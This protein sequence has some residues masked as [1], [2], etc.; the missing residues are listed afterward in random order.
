MSKTGCVKFFNDAKGFGFITPDDGGDDLFAHR[1][2]IADSQALQEGDTVRFDEGWDDMKGK[3]NATNIT[4]GTGGFS[5]GGGKGKGGGTSFGGGG[6]G[7]CFNCG[8][9]G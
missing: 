9:Y 2:Q 3:S 5:T 7:A 6:G 4:G 8:E 1:N